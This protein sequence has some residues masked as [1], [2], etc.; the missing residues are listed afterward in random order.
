MSFN[1]ASKNL[2]LTDTTVLHLENPATGEPLY[3]DEAETLPLTIELYGKA[4]K[5]H[6]KYFASLVRKAEMDQKSKKKSK[7]AEEILADNADHFATLTKSV[8]NFDLDGL[9]L[10]NKEAFKKMYSDARLL[11]INEQ[12]NVKLG[13]QESFLQK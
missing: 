12:V 7:T 6:Q 4:S 5:V 8:N 9:V 3:A 1:I 11:W 13:D 2:L 10:D